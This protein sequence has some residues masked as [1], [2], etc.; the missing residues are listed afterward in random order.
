MYKVQQHLKNTCEMKFGHLYLILV[1]LHGLLLFLPPIANKHPICLYFADTDTE[2]K[3]ELT[4]SP[5]C[6][7]LIAKNP[8]AAAR[9]FHFIC[10]NFIKHVLGIGTDHPGLYGKTDGLSR[11]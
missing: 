2:F 7:V 4:F 10:E 11:W 9:F 3:P 1:L 6:S 8:V 5:E